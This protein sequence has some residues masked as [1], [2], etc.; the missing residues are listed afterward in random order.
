MRSFVFALALFAAA[1]GERATPQPA[2]EA[3]DVAEG[4]VV[5]VS[6]AWAAPT[7][8]GVAVSAGYLTLTN[9]A[10]AADALIGATSP[11]AGRVEVH[12]INAEGAVMRMRATPRLE[13]AP[14][15]T[16]TLEPG[17][18]HLMFYDVATP[19]AEGETIP[20]TLMFASGTEVAVDLPVSRRPAGQHQGH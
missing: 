6:N 2:A 12:E 20:V 9:P 7:P 1:C 13:I 4:A 8:A 11:R 14:G 19:F 3:Q 10:A 17:G 18:A 16:V 15:S 5:S